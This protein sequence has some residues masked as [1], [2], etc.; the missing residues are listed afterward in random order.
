MNYAY[1]PIEIKKKIISISYD[2]D[3]ILKDI[4]KV[5]NVKNFV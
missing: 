1:V 3:K 4:F 2:I 5:E